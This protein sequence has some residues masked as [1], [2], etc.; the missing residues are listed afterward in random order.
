MEDRLTYLREKAAALPRS[1]GVYIMHNAEGTVIYVGKSR[2]L[3]DRVS[4]Y[5][6]GAHDPKTT[7]MAANVHDFRF[8][9]CT[10]EME[11]LALENS[12]I[13]QYAPKYNVRLKDAKSY[14]Y[15]RISIKE[16][17]PRISVTRRRAADG[18]LYF[19]PY[20]SA[21][22]AYGVLS[23]LERTLGIPSCKKQFPE[24]IG[25]DRPCVFFQIG[26]CVGL[27]SGKVSQTEYRELVERAAVVLRGGTRDILVDLTE[28]MNRA[29]EELE[30]EKAARYRDGVAA[31]RRLGEKQKAVGS[32][33]VECDVVGLHIASFEN[34]DVRFRDCASIF[35]IRSGYI[36]DS[37]HFFFGSDEI[38]PENLGTPTQETDAL[39]E[40]D[41]PLSAFIVGL[42]QTREYIPREI[43]LSFELPEHEIDLLTEYVSE[44][45]GHRVTIRTPRRGAG[46]Y[47]C[48]MAIEDAKTHAE[49]TR[50][51]E[52]G[53]E[54]TL[55]RLASLLSLEVYPSRIE[56]YDISNLGKEHIT[57]GM[58]VMIDG[59]FKKSEYRTFNIRNQEQPDDYAAMTEAISRRMAH[60]ATKGDEND[61]LAAYPD[62]I[63]LDGGKGHV[64]VIR[65]LL[66][67]LGFNVPV[68][69]MVKDDHHKTRTITTEEYEVNIARYPDVFKLV[70]GI[71]EETHRY[72]VG[73]MTRAKQKTL[74]SSTLENVRGIG[75]KKARLLLSHFSSMKALKAASVDQLRAVEGISQTDAESIYEYFRTEK[76]SV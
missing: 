44:R 50:L 71:Q 63:L 61:P 76:N 58:V 36:S 1:P 75:P 41:S 32:P 30:F 53:A 43:L 16:Q 19:G 35:Y 40:E 74:T 2:S 18:S 20:S 10:T 48:D 62:L 64:G 45:A 29:A 56:A 25:K 11:A 47:L 34:A 31:L 39:N 68:F 55:A 38:L 37:E 9:V 65:E 60:I 4:Q 73:R 17:Y 26:R 21:Q 46:R 42:Y 66:D 51:R 70:Y 5:F 57:A 27:C 69:G 33:D 6:H 67:R 14:P 15:I 8:V 54:K 24:A 13:K 59:K 28:K 12:L 49:N 72:A 3:R 7:K 52:N 23:S 22:T